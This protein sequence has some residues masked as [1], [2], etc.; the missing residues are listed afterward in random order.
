MPVV[1][2]FCHYRSFRNISVSGSKSEN[3]VQR[4][5]C[6]SISIC[7]VDVTCFTVPS[8]RGGFCG[9][10]PKQSSKPLQI[11]KWNAINQWSFCQFLEC[12]A[13]PHKRKAS[14]QKRKAPYWKLSGDGSV[15]SS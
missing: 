1:E 5:V 4:F 3:I 10:S 11:E 14:L 12:Q 2:A 6:Y 7:T 9:L 8:P 15:A 13:P